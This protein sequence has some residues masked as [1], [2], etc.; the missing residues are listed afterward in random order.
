MRVLVKNDQNTVKCFECIDIV[1]KVLYEDGVGIVFGAKCVDNNFKSEYIELLPKKDLENL[2]VEKVI[3]YIIN[4]FLP[5][6]LSREV[7]DFVN[8]EKLLR[9]NLEKN[10]LIRVEKSKIKRSKK[11]IDK[12]K[13][14]D[15]KIIE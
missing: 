11:M 4:D 5:S 12:V 1:V 10:K 3:D 15:A 2:E 7:I 14:S 13:Y 6:L 8:I 9:E